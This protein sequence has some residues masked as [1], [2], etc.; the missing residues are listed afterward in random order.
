MRLSGDV[1]I[2][3]GML[4]SVNNGVITTVNN[5]TS[6]TGVTVNG[7]LQINEATAVHVFDTLTNAS[8]STITMSA[9]TTNSELRVGSDTVLSGGGTL[10]MQTNGCQ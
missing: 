8:G 3:G 7:D 5:A 4:Q 6:F 10:A 2:T 1:A 9:A